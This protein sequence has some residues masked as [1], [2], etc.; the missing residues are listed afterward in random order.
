MTAILTDR[1]IKV[2]RNTY[3]NEVT[4]LEK[5]F[6]SHYKALCLYSIHITDN[7]DA[8]EDI[9]MSS[10]VAMI[11]KRLDFTQI[12]DI[13]KYAYKVV[14]NA[15]VDFVR[16][17]NNIPSCIH[18][19]DDRA[20]ISSDMQERCEREARLWE[21]IDNLPPTCRK[22]F[23]MSKRD[24][25]SYKDIADTLGISTKTVEAHISKAFKLLR[26]RKKQIYTCILLMLLLLLH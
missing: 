2:K 16:R 15:S 22:V 19:I 1:Q 18:Q 7:I 26:K 9:V 25:M 20:D 5:I 4:P 13:K 14:H 11:E 21:A 17:Q 8:A 6:K 12:S 23:I 24:G 10:F 3:I